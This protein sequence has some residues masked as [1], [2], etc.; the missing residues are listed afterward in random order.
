M[1]YTESITI[2]AK[3]ISFFSRVIRAFEISGMSRAAQE[4]HRLGYYKEYQ[5]ALEQL[6]KLR[7]E[8]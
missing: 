8:E 3:K 7:D 1:F 2:P 5:R 6:R 4:L